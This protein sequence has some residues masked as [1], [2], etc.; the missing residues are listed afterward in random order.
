M[1]CLRCCVESIQRP[2]NP[3]NQPRFVLRF[4]GGPP[5]GVLPNP[6]D[7]PACP[8]QGAVHQPVAG[9][10]AGE[11]LLPKRTV[12][13]GLR[14][15]PGTPMPETAVHKHCEPRLPENKIRFAE[16]FLIP[17]PSGDL[18][19]PEKLCERYFRGLVATPTNQAH[20]FRTLR[21]GEDIRHAKV[22]RNLR[23]ARDAAPFPPPCAE[24]S[25]RKVLT[26][27]HR[28]DT[29]PRPP[30]RPRLR[31]ATLRLR[32]VSTR[33]ASHFRRLQIRPGAGREINTQ[34]S[35]KLA[36]NFPRVV[37]RVVGSKPAAIRGQRFAGSSECRWNFSYA[38]ALPGFQT[39]ARIIL[40]LITSATISAICRASHGGTAFPT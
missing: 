13:G 23:P 35:T 28:S 9:L 11:L 32:S 18:I 19:A 20:H 30:V 21:F 22:L 36:Q 25:G 39:F 31:D 17:P 12:A 7:A 14:A 38:S 8:A 6:K 1:R 33:A 26:I 4:H 16:D 37:L 5:Q 10:V 24:T 27:A 15:M 3:P 2:L 34:H 29:I 40:Q